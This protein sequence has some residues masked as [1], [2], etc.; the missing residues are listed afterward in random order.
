MPM[1]AASQH[2]DI[3]L[4]GRP[5]PQELE[6]GPCSS[7]LEF[8][9]PSSSS[10]THP[11][12]PCSQGSAV[13]ALQSKV[14]ALSERKAIWKQPSKKNQGKKLVPGSYMLGHPLSWVS[15]SSDEETEPDVQTCT[16]HGV[17]GE[18]SQI[19]S[20]EDDFNPALLALPRGLGE[21]ASLEDIAQ[22]DN[23]CNAKQDVSLSSCNNKQW[24]PPK[25]FWK[26]ARPE[27]LLLNGEAHVGLMKM[28]SVVQEEPQ[29]ADS[30]ES[31]LHTCGHRRTAPAEPIGSAL[32]RAESLES[33][34]SA[35]SSLSLAERVE[36]NRNILR[37]M[38]QK[39]QSKGGEGHQA[40]ITEQ[41][42]ENVHRGKA[43][44]SPPNKKMS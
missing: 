9:L 13:S 33:V 19:L 35:G 25:G 6:V 14:K 23:I 30:L 38:L 32:W 17:E 37:Q 39:T 8:G 28:D 27:T 43:K 4:E 11:H 36:M 2:H 1:G 12:M 41:R 20:D 3:Q 26:V 16:F 40:V 7:S 21:G 44:L 29:R 15:S 31:P 22:D 5:E 18:P 24:A 10:H 34:C 42:L